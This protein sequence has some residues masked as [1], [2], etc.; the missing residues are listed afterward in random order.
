MQPGSYINKIGLSA[1]IGTYV[2][3]YDKEEKKAPNSALYFEKAQT[4]WQGGRGRTRAG[5]PDAGSSC[6]CCGSLLL[7]AASSW[8]YLGVFPPWEVL[9][10]QQK[11]TLWK[12]T[13]SCLFLR[14]IM[15]KT[16]ANWMGLMHRV[17]ARYWESRNSLPVQGDPSRVHKL[18]LH[19]TYCGRKT[20]CFPKSVRRPDS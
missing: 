4:V 16:W 3:R 2:I 19:L 18:S 7:R 12:N 9:L 5:L 20:G 15:T 11:P 10:I 6:L 14:I 17:P 1:Q 8:N 13:F